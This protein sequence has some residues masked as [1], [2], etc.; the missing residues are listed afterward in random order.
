M[1]WFSKKSNN[2]LNA[3]T[4]IN[5]ACTNYYMLIMIICYDRNEKKHNYKKKSVELLHCNYLYATNNNSF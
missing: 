5:I 2:I 3:N 1:F 4:T